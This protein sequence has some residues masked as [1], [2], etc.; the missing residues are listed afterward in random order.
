M[1]VTYTFG[2]WT[3]RWDDDFNGSGQIEHIYCASGP[4]VAEFCLPDRIISP[5]GGMYST[6]LGAWMSRWG[7]PGSQIESQSGPGA[8]PWTVTL[9]SA[10]PGYPFDPATGEPLPGPGP[11]GGV[12]G[13]WTEDDVGG[14]GVDATPTS[15]PPPPR[16]TNN[17]EGG[18]VTLWLLGLP[19]TAAVTPTSNG[20][21]APLKVYEVSPQYLPSGF[22]DYSKPPIRTLIG[23]YTVGALGLAPDGLDLP[24]NEGIGYEAVFL[25][26]TGHRTPPRANWGGGCLKRLIRAE[27]VALPAGV[28]EAQA[29]ELPDLKFPGLLRDP[30]RVQLGEDQSGLFRDNRVSL[31]YV[32]GAPVT[33]STPYRIGLETDPAEGVMSF[34]LSSRRLDTSTGLVDWT[35][36][37]VLGRLSREYPFPGGF[38]DAAAGPFTPRQALERLLYAMR[39]PDADKPVLREW[40]GWEE[41]PELYLRSEYGPVLPLLEGLIVEEPQ[42]GPGPNAQDVLRQ[43]F[44]PFSGYAFRA[45]EWGRLQ[46]VPPPWAPKQAA[47]VT[48]RHTGPGMATGTSSALSS[49]T[50]LT[51]TITSSESTSAT[52]PSGRTDLTADWQVLAEKTDEA[53]ATELIAYRLR[54]RL[55]A[56]NVEL[57]LTDSGNNANRVM[58]A[59]GVLTDPAETHPPV[60]TL[61]DADLEPGGTRVLDESDIVNTCTVTSQGY[62]W[63]DGQQVIPPQTFN[64]G[65][66]PEAN[67][68]APAATLKYGELIPVG[69]GMIVAGGTLALSIGLEGDAPDAFSGGRKGYGIPEPVQVSLPAVHGASTTLRIDAGAAWSLV[70]ASVELTITYVAAP[71]TR[72]GLR[73]TVNRVWG[74]DVRWAI[75]VSATGTAY[76]K[77]NTK[78]TASY[79]ESQEDQTADLGAS[80]STYGRRERTLDTGVYQ[81]N[82]ATALSM[83]RAVVQEHL[84][85]RE[86]LT[87]AQAPPYPVR[88]EH[89]GRLV[90]LPGA[91]GVVT[92]WSYDEQHTPQQS[93]SSSQFTVSAEQRLVLNPQPLPDGTTLTRT[94][95]RRYHRARWDSVRLK[96]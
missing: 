16:P 68:E 70:M 7:V 78:I 83:A 74:N 94:S 66:I 76:A 54:A 40:L 43:F 20:M 80:R 48:V 39:Q 75:T 38:F 84:N 34:E 22:P 19:V 85:P 86:V 46:V 23:N 65:G 17:C 96:E 52:L 35:G 26:V 32:D 51:W 12:G 93:Q 58:R 21:Q 73:V 72:G 49:L 77:S 9:V 29:A 64:H 95:E 18:S 63:A 47:A 5:L 30:V 55:N 53:G 62:T 42:D 33:L 91:R 57:E 79:G 8:N 28:T 56:G 59:T 67:P 89:V 27:Y 13:P 10:V 11:T 69:E 3:E 90:D 1:S 45:S 71:G 82:Q 50:R 15:P 37:T 4:G 88:P 92:G 6:A 44:E 61:T 25:P 60:L 41:L 24:N 31:T 87:L 2:A 14:D 81:V 36:E